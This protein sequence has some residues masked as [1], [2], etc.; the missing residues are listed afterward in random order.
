MMIGEWIDGI[1]NGFGINTSFIN[2]RQGFTNQNR[3]RSGPR[4]RKIRE[5]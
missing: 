5:I 4:D 3:L 1:Q 2:D